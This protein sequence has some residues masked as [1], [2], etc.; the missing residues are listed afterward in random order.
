MTDTQII[1]SITYKLL[2]NNGA[3]TGASFVTQMYDIPQTLAALNQRQW[4]FLKDTGCIVTSYTTTLLAGSTVI[5]VPADYI[6]TRRVVWTPAGGKPVSLNRVDKEELDLWRQLWE[7]EPGTPFG[8]N[9]SLLPTRQLQIAPAPA[10]NGTLSIL[11]V[12]SPATLTNSDVELTV[13]DI[14]SW[15]I[16]YGIMADLLGSDGEGFDPQRAEY[17]EMRYGMGVELCRLLLRGSEEAA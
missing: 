15:A 3:A 6:I 17:C 16:E 10:D 2:E 8:Y 1:K 7:A 4:R 5:S 11:Y 9:E 12:A 14:F 13:P